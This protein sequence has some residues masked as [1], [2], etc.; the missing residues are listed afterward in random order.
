MALPPTLLT[1]FLCPPSL[2]PRGSCARAVGMSTVSE[3][4]VAAHCGLRVLG[5]SLITNACLGPGDDAPAPSHEEVLE[6]RALI[7]LWGG[8]RGE[9]PGR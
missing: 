6:V 8:R 3:V 5:L 4:S 9:A 2:L 7:C 1:P